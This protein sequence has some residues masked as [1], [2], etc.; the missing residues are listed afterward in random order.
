LRALRDGEKVYAPGM[1]ID[2]Y[3][4]P[5]HDLTLFVI[6]GKH[7]SKESI[8][9]FEDLGA[10]CATRWLKYLDPT[11][12]MA[13]VELASLPALKRVKREKRMELFGDRPK[14]FAI[15]GSSGPS[16][17]LFLEFWQRYADSD[18]NERCF[19][20]LDEAY[21]WLGLSE[22]VRAAVA[23]VIDRQDSGAGA[24]RTAGDPITLEPRGD[25]AAPGQP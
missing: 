2:L 9:M 14:P 12:D 16:Q 20:S 10:E 25:R 13:Q 4:L 1:P 15:A 3:S 8:R 21:D 6:S 11:A 23:G 18:S 19:G 22:A 5:E 17:Q 7:S 24:R